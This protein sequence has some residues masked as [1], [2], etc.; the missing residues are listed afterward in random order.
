M[1]VF[2]INLLKFVGV[3]RLIMQILAG[4]LRLNGALENVVMCWWRDWARYT[5]LEHTNA[6][7]C[8]YMRKQYLSMLT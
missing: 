6:V 1:F 3:Q 2:I 7:V 8:K 4:L 5:S